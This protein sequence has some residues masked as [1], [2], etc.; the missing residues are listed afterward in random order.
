MDKGRARQ[1][2]AANIIDTVNRELIDRQHL[3][4]CGQPFPRGPSFC[5]P[6]FSVGQLPAA[7]S[8]S[9]DVI[10]V[11]QD[12]DQAAN[13]QV[14]YSIQVELQMSLRRNSQHDVL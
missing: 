4:K 12:R 9:L 5:G 1:Q 10:L 6:P 3:C 8:W 13:V 7:T 2:I 14:R 11:S